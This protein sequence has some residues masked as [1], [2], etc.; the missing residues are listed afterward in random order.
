MPPGPE[1]LLFQLFVIFVAAKIVGE[2][3]ER[4][5]LPAVLGEILAGA[6]F[7]PYAL[8]LI[9]PTETIYSVAEIGAIFVL[10]HA[11]LE[12]SPKDLIRVGHKSLLVA[13][14]GVV[15][16]FVLGFSYMKLRGDGTTEATF[17]GAAMVATSVGITARVLGDLGVLAS[18][19]ARIILG[20][21]VFDDILGMLLLAVVAGL[22]SGVGVGWIHLGVLTTEAA[23]FAIF[24]IFLGSR[25]IRPLRRRVERLST[26]NAP[27]ILALAICLLFSWMAAKIGMAAIIGAFFAGLVFADY[28]PEWELLP[29]VDS[30]TDFLSP[31]FFFSIGSRLD[32]SMLTGNLLFAA[33]VVSLLAIISKLVGCGLPLLNEG[34]HT[35]LTVGV[36]MMPRGEVALIVALVGLNSHI[37]TQPTYAIVVFMSAVT[38][39]LAPPLLRYLFSIGPDDLTEP[40]HL[41]ST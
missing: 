20:A 23:V 28:S 3:F 11:G 9:H 1:K 19:S 30:I 16:P 31:F 21:A 17:V 40:R 4:L 8:G 2:I 10:F 15:V 37:V 39:L 32:I 26:H 33:I 14:V 25:M 6:T 34:W 27:L 7:G 24:M 41:E 12:T 36:G 13:V 18:Y 22:A 35:V 29:N 5:R 38:T